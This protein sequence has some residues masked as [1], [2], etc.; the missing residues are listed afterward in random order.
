MEE[1]CGTTKDTAASLVSSSD[2]SG[3]WQCRGHCPWSEISQALGP[4]FDLVS[5]QSQ[6]KGP[7]L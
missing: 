4:S 6:S 5:M 1:D 7:S 2:A 3:G